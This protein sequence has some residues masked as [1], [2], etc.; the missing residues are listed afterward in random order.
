MDDS[1]WTMVCRGLT[2]VR[3]WQDAFLLRPS[4]L[5]PQTLFLSSLHQGK[6]ANF[7]SSRMPF[8]V[9]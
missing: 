3:L 4:I 6:V 5:P 8:S 1:L 7:S 2:V 9:C